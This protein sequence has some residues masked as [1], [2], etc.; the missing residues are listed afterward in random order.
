[1]AIFLL[2]PNAAGKNDMDWV[3]SR[4]SGPCI[5]AADV[6]WE[7]RL[8]ATREFCAIG[9]SL[10]VPSPWSR[11]DLVNAEMRAEGAPIV[12]GQV[13]PVYTFAELAE[14]SK[15]WP[16]SNVIAGSEYQPAQPTVARH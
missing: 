4:H 5:V 13:V 6:E 14:V 1:M 2:T 7:A 10:D 15:G 16:Q 3:S 11:A 12:N 9:G 8:H